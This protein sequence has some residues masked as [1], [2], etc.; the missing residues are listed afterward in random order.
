MT[1]KIYWHRIIAETFTGTKTFLYPD[2]YKH[3]NELD[4]IFAMCDLDINGYPFTHEYAGWSEFP[5]ELNPV[6]TYCWKE[7]E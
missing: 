1:R 5:I 6:I 2:G 3:W 7:E 4:I